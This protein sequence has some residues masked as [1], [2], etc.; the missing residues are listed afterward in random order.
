MNVM[1]NLLPDIRLAKQRERTRRQLFTGVSLLICGVGIGV[2]VILFLT[3]ASQKLI[4][5]TLSSN[6]TAKT[7]TLQDTPDLI[8][9]LT[10][11]EH[12]AALPTLYSNRVYFTKFFA[13]YIQASPTDVQISS[14]SCDPLNAVAITGTAK[15]Y[16][17]VAKLAKALA[18]LNV[19]VGTGANTSN[20]PY[21][22]NV[23]IQT[24]ALS[25]GKVS[26]TIN[27]TASTEVTHGNN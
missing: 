17:S 13:A 18:A 8:D 1:I 21:F 7:K 26:F 23:V 24:V 16:A 2:V 20:A 4:I 22:T 9:A 25:S 15:S 27:T 11:Q 12:S 6:I 3:T 14:L 5:A 19:S 10:A